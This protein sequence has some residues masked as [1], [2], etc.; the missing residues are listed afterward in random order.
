MS[1]RCAPCAWPSGRSP[2]FFTESELRGDDLDEH[3]L[4]PLA[5]ELPVEDLLPGAEVEATLGRARIETFSQKN[6]R[7][8]IE[9]SF[10]RIAPV[11]ERARAAGLPVRAYLSC[12]LG[13]P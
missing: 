8:G 13:C 10:R 7:C 4:A 11:V 12:V 3:P 9:Q 5:V 2:R 6:I 1:C